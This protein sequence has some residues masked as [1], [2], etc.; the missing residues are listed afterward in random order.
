MRLDPPSAGGRSGSGGLGD[1]P[2]PVGLGHAAGR[3]SGR[4]VPPLGRGTAFFRSVAHVGR[5]AAQGLAYAHA[6]GI[7]HRDI[8]PSNLLLDHAG[9]V[10]ITDFGLAKGEDD[11]LTLTGDIL[12]TYRYM[13]PERFRGGGD[14]RADI[15]ALGLTLYELAALRPAFDSTDRLE[16]IERI[17]GEEPPRPRAIDP[18]IPRDLETIVLKAIEKAPEARYRSAEAMA[19]DLRRF[20]AD[21]PIE[22]RQVSTIERCWR[23]ARRN[24]LLAGVIGALIAVLTLATAISILA[25]ERFA[26]LAEDRK[27]VAFNERSARLDADQ[28]RN[29]AGMR[30]RAERWERYRS[31]IAEAAAAQQLQNSST[32][33]RALEAAPAEY[34]NWEWRHFHSLLHGAISVMPVPGLDKYTLRLSPDGRQVAVGSLRGEVHLFEAA[35]GRPA[36]A[37]RGDG[38]AVDSFEYSPDGRRLAC[39]FVD[40]LIRIWDPATGRPLVVLR[41][42]PD[43]IPAIPA[44][45]PRWPADHDVRA[46]GRGRERSV[47]PLGRHDR[48]VDRP[49]GR[50]A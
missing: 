27:T 2:R 25:A 6:S 30:E 50:R 39:G 45:Q 5:Q 18:R 11:G 46:P 44:I 10:W 41:R 15:Y 12:G 4:D 1:G 9:I 28:A 35:T 36:M 16:L 22:A 23:L 26:R 33:E 21:E 8:K 37:L 47:Q 49:P 48:P 34:R 3:P 20:L 40:G 43:F 31:N 24:P 29:E 17:K 13:A 42:A 38:A 14:A 19:E 7:V 32:G